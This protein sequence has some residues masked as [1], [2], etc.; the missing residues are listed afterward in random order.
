ML[1]A[2]LSGTFE[3]ARLGA[4]SSGDERVTPID[5]GVICGGA[6]ILADALQRRLERGTTE[7]EIARPRR[8]LQADARPALHGRD[9]RVPHPRRP[10]RQ[11]IRPRRPAPEREA[12][13]PLRRRRG[14]AAQARARPREG[15]RRVRGGSSWRRPR[16]RRTC[17]SASATRTRPRT[18]RS[19]SSASEPPGR[20]ASLDIV[21]TLGPVIG[22]HGGPGTL[23]LFWFQDEPA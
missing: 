19:S 9:A 10:R 11:G 23:G 2:K 17:T 18:P 6:V 8:A 14:C 12:D 3:S 5:S 1:S 16:T 13:P 4:E 21:T 7:E 20:G 22:T 15:A